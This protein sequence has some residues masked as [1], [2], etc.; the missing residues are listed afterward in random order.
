MF[1][2]RGAITI[3]EDS[4][5]EI[6]AK[7]QKL[8]KR[9]VDDNGLLSPGVSIV[10]CIFSSTKDI[11]AYYPAAAAREGG[12]GFPMFSC[13][14]PEIAGALKLCIRVLIHVNAGGAKFSPKHIYLN[15]AVILRPDLQ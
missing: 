1:A 15:G 9:I 5:S 6:C 13:Q 12:F 2:V 4:V 8:L 11:T 10:S 7:T 14:E 3:D